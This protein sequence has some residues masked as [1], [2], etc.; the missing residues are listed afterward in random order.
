MSISDNNPEFEVLLDYL[1]QNCGCDLTGYKRDSLMRRFQRRMQQ[2]NIENY[3]HYLQYLQ[4]HP[5][6]CS[7]LL[8]TI[9]IN[10][11]GFFRDRDCWDYLANQI[12]P[13]IITGKQPHERIRVWSAGCA[14]GQEVYTLVMLLAEVLGIEQYLQR[15]QILATDVDEDTIAQARRASYS[16]LEVADIPS[17]A[18]SKYFE[19]IEQRY[20]FD[21]KLRRTIFFGRHDLALD[22]PMSKIDLLVCRNVLIYFQPETQATVLVRFHFALTDNGFLFLGK[23]ESLTNNKQIFT[24]VSLKHRIFAKG[25]KL[26]LQDHLLIRPQTRNKKAVNDLTMQSHIWQTAFVASPFAQ[27][28]L[29]SSGRLILAN[30]QAYATF[31]LKNNDLG[32]RVQDLEIGRIVNSFA[33]IR[34]LRDWAKNSANGDRQPISL[35]NVKWTTDDNTTYLEI[36]MAP[37]SDPSGSLIG[38]ILTFVD[39]TRYTKL[40]NELEQTKSNL[41][42]VSLELQSTQDVLESTTLQLNFTQNELEIVHQEMQLMSHELHNIKD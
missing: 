1:K 11:S 10:F 34:Q 31:T 14:S 21:S 8:D 5:Q 33:L 15:V 4:N 27:I 24:P 2:L 3:A 30:N 19:Q 16:N 22:A 40:E 37:I 41:A 17:E 9:F 6:E 38:A 39:V 7:P 35:K 12:I 20:V 42:K 26:T 23:S 28:A 32:A 13:Q 18:L 29:D 36:H 25:Q